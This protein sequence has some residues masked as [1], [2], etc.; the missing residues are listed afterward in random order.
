MKIG[1]KLLHQTAKYPPFKTFFVKLK[2]KILCFVLPL[3]CLRKQ[4]SVFFF[5][6]RISNESFELRGTKIWKNNT[7]KW[8]A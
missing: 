7:K 3:L 8:D 2:N 1:I 5:Y 6:E 4:Y